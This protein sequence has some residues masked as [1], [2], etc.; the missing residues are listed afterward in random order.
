MPGGCGHLHHP[1]ASEDDDRPTSRRDRVVDAL[2]RLPEL[3]VHLFLALPKQ[4]A[5]GEKVSGTREPPVPIAL[6]VEALMRDIAST[7]TTWERIVRDTASLTDVGESRQESGVAVD[8]ACRTLAA[9]VDTLLA[10]PPTSVWEWDDDAGPAGTPLGCHY[11]GDRTRIGRMA[12]PRGDAP[13]GAY[14]AA[15]RTGGDAARTIIALAGR[16]RVLLGMTRLVHRL[17]VPCPTCGVAA[18]TREDGASE[19][20]CQSCGRAEPEERYARLAMILAEDMRGQT[21]AR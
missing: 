1:A 19:V 4:G 13:D 21:E 18:L 20:R 8:R 15:D 10:C 7:V 16:C 12:L 9:H 5:A 2:A 11:Q 3:Y 17:P 6:E 14:V